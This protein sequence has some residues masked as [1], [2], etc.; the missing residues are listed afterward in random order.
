[1]TYEYGQ[2]YDPAPCKTGRDAQLRPSGYHVGC[3][4]DFGVRDLHAGP[5]EWTHSPYGRGD[6]SGL[7][8][9]RGGNGRAGEVVGRCANVESSAPGQR[10]GTI[11]FRCCAGPENAATVQL[12]PSFRPGLVPRASFPEELERSLIA[13]L[14][15]QS[16]EA[17]EV[18]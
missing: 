10:S 3:Q 8:A 18:G 5:F 16:K 11:G 9:V 2:S 6:T 1:R 13:A 14:P 12:E 7:V 15:A 4:S 17:L